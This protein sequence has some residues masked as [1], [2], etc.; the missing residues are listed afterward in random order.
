[1]DFSQRHLSRAVEIFPKTLTH[2][3]NRGPIMDDFFNYVSTHPVAAIIIGALVLI[4]A[5]FVFKKLLKLALIVGL[6]LVVVGGY[7]YYKAPAEF[8]KNVKST[9]G[10]VKGHAENTLKKGKSLL[11]KGKDLV[12]D[13]EEK[14]KKARK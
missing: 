12:E 10:E 4:V 2:R 7:Y 8:S 5:Y 1:M 6:I 9:L 11:Q 14:V 13:L 3:P